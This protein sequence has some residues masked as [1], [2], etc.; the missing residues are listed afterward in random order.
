MLGSIV[1]ET[2]L[3]TENIGYQSV[4]E[5]SWLKQDALSVSRVPNVINELPDSIDFLVLDG[6]EFS[7]RAEF[8]K[9]KDRSNY[10]FLDDTLARKNI[11]NRKDLLESKEFECLGDYPNDRNGWAYF[12]RI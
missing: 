9:L 4:D 5:E 10:I 3:D 8:L 7:T 2:E 12:K 6:G 11:K 1:E